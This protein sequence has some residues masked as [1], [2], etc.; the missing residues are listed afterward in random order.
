MPESGDGYA[1]LTIDSSFVQLMKALMPEPLED[2]NTVM[3]RFDGTTYVEG[4]SDYT[5]TVKVLW[6]INDFYFY[7]INDVSDIQTDQR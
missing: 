5:I 4:T 1:N 6:K 7:C 2:G 3:Q